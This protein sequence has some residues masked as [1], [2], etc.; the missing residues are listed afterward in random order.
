MRD[1]EA[2]MDGS[3]FDTWTRRRFGLAAGGLITA[4]LTLDPARDG[5]AKRK[6]RHK[7]RK[8]CGKQQKRCQGTCIKR[9]Q[10]CVDGDCPEDTFC[11]D[12]ECVSLDTPCHPSGG[13][14]CFAEDGVLRQSLEGDVYCTRTSDL[15]FC[16]QCASSEGCLDDERCFAAHCAEDVTAVCRKVYVDF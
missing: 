1:A 15:L 16:A 12:G 6:K 4:L 8:S 5:A 9:T 11:C 13:Y 10:C 3:Q 7:H 2:A 14:A